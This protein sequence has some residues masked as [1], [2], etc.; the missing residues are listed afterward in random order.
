[1]SDERYAGIFVFLYGQQSAGG[2]YH[3]HTHAYIFIFYAHSCSLQLLLVCRLH[4][5]PTHTHLCIY[6]CTYVRIPVNMKIN[7]N[8]ICTDTH[9]HAHMHVCIVVYTCHLLRLKRLIWNW[10]A[11]VG[12]VV[13][14]N[15]ELH[16]FVSE[17]NS[18]A[19]TNIQTYVRICHLDLCM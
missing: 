5:M 4:C 17:L 12:S 18:K 6:I 8:Q 9:T 13:Q 2:R 15:N 1:M 14:Q 16:W 10:V 7:S 11:N 19:S 3:I